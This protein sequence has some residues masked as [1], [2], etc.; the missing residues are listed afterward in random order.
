MGGKGPLGGGAL[1][2]WVEWPEDED[3]LTGL[4]V[5]AIGGC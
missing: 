3:D 5:L 2:L 1:R 4:P